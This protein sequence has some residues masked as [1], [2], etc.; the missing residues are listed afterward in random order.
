[1]TNYIFLEVKTI[2]RKKYDGY[3]SIDGFPI[4]KRFKLAKELDRVPSR[5]IVLS[6]SE[7]ERVDELLEK[8]IVISFHDH[9]IVFPENMEDLIDYIR[10]G[11]T[12]LAYEGLAYSG[13]DI[14]F[15]GLLDGIALIH[16]N[17]PWSWDNI[18]TQ[19]GTRLSDLAMQDMI[20][21]VEGV[22]D[23]YRASREEKIGL[24]LHLEG[25]PTGVGYDL[26]KLDILYGLGVRCIGI[27]YSIGNELGGGIADKVDRGLTDLGYK[28]IER[29]NK[30]GILIDLAHVGDKTSLEAIEASDKPLAI[31]HAGAR[32]LWPSNRMKP[33]EVIYALADKDGVFGV[34]A[35][36]HT[37]LTLNRRKHDLDAVMEHFQYIVDLVGIDYVAFG[38]DTLYGDHV[39]LHK[40][41][42]RLLSIDKIISGDLPEYEEVE[43]VDGLENPTQFK[44]IVRWLVKNGYSDDEISKVIGGNIIR[45]LKTVWRR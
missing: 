5:E 9:P 42:R 34:E 16:G 37:T 17:D 10:T 25:A 14:V 30:L 13:L 41:F 32:S 19:I 20:I 11:Y 12:A 26:Q 38:P 4:L 36:P 3:R 29:C 40:Y 43:Y 6:K 21:K 44:N 39:A 15:D 22:E 45:L 28:F 31:T 18:I 23:I 8:N 24:I 35:A 1:V 2:K 27:T 7:E 33:D